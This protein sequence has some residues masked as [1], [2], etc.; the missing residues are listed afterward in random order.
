MRRTY[1]FSESDQLILT[2]ASD[3]ASN[4]LVWRRDGA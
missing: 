3:E 2:A 4:R 1:G